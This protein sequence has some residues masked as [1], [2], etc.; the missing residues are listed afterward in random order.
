MCVCGNDNGDENMSLPTILDSDLMCV[1]VVPL[2]LCRRG[3]DD[4]RCQHLE[5]LHRVIPVQLRVASFWLCTTMQKRREGR[6]GER[7]GLGWRKAWFDSLSW[8]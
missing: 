6:I 8:G 7:G 4:Q 2:S 3:N 1:R 5:R